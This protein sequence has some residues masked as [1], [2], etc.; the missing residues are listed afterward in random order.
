M[1]MLF[2][3]KKRDI[4]VY[5]YKCSPVLEGYV[6]VLFSILIFLLYM[7]RVALKGGSW[8]E[9]VLFGTIPMA[10]LLVGLYYIFKRE[11][12][13]DRAVVIGTRMSDLFFSHQRLFFCYVI[14][15]YI[16][17]YAVVTLLLSFVENSF[18]FSFHAWFLEIHDLSILLL[19]L[20]YHAVSSWLT[21]YQYVQ[22]KVNAVEMK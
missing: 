2:K 12:P 4:K 11:K 15:A 10:L 9:Y 22:N 17:S 19:A 6:Y 7:M 3:R 16:L 1:K 21:Y 13:L 5:S 8:I 14:V 18:V 20:V